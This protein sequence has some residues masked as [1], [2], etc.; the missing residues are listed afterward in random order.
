MVKTK[1]MVASIYLAIVSL[2]NRVVAD[3]IVFQEPKPDSV[4]EESE[5][6]QPLYTSLPADEV[7]PQNQSQAD[8]VQPQNQAQQ[9]YQLKGC[10]ACHGLDAKTP[11]Q[12]L[13]PKLA[14]QNQEYIIAQLRDFKSGA[15]HNGLSVV[16]RGALSPIKNDDEIKTIAEWLASLTIEVDITEKAK[17]AELYKSKNF[18]VDITETAKGA[19]LYKSKNCHACHGEKAN[20]PILPNYPKL[21]GQ[22][23]KYLIAQMKDI[24]RG[25]RK[26][27]NSVVM[28]GIMYSVSDKE[29]TV[30]AQWLESLD[31]KE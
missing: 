16:M 5:I 2:N 1:W 3:E 4:V 25:I 23:Y 30:I 9:L 15:R 8:E 29:I 18:E 20:T 11:S 10:N 6:T 28:K 22:N 14:G 7:Q 12:P 21:A 19:K 26:N 13:Y 27:G 24:K 31:K 17:E